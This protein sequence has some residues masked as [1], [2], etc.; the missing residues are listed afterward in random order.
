MKRARN[1]SVQQKA[2]A[3]L[4]IA[5]QF[6]LGELDTEKPHPKTTE[7]SCLVETDLAQAVSI[8]KDIDLAAI[9][10]MAAHQDLIQKMKRD[11]EETLNNN[12][13]VFLVG[14]GSTGRLSLALEVF[15]RKLKKGTKYS[16]SVVSFMAGGDTAII[17]SIEDFEDYPDFAARQ[18]KELGFRQGDLLIACT[19]G[20][21]TPFVIGAAE[22]ALTLSN[23]KPYFLYCNPDEILMG[24]TDRTTRTLKNSSIVKINLSVG[25]MSLSGS[26]RMQATTVLMY[27]VGLALLN[28]F[29]E[30]DV[31]GDIQFLAE[32][33]KQT[34]FSFLQDFILHESELY[35]DGKFL[36]YQTHDDLGIS[37]LTD[38]TERA[39]TFTLHPFENS[40]VDSHPPSLVYLCLPQAENSREAW[41]VLLGREPRALGW[42]SYPITDQNYLYGFDF[43]QAVIEKRTKKVA[44]A[45][46]ISFEIKRTRNH[47]EFNFNQKKHSLK[48]EGL[49]L[50]QQ[51]VLIKI[52]LNTHSTLVMGKLGRYESNLM[53]W[54]KASNNKLIDR[55]ARYI[56]LLLKRKGIEL[57]YADILYY[58][59]EEIEKNYENK[60]L[61]LEAVNRI[62]EQEAR[63]RNANMGS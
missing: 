53:T 62:C 12:G 27:A 19:E 2:D 42:E 60:S 20:G 13:R 37:I 8:M 43:S 1:A 32:L 31:K 50:L 61:V 29:E 56:D 44:P 40:F 45:E 3:F 47:F 21:E 22:T 55:A 34:D 59:F 16:E 17:K 7:L 33:I 11:M 23:R 58:L 4:K 9:G 57:S 18:L 52:I 6:R 46:L 41:Q 26:T 63:T 25:P 38:T 10:S 28:V 35:Q 5:P 51:Q 39:P 49:N 24:L 30:V 15:W 54:V 48:I 36:L 14:C